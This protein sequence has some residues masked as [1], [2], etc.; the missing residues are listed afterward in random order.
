MEE[1]RYLFKSLSA[2]VQSS[3]D[4][5]HRKVKIYH[6]SERYIPMT[7]HLALAG[8]KASFFNRK[9]PPPEPGSGRGNHVLRPDVGISVKRRPF[10]ESPLAA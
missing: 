7:K 6:N 10:M 9:S 2:S 1:K 8:R 5:L 4:T 3:Q